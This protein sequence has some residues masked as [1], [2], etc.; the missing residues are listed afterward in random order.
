MAGFKT[1]LPCCTGIYSFIDF[2]NK[3]RVYIQRES[4]NDV[5]FSTIVVV[6]GRSDCDV[7]RREVWEV[8]AKN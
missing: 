3:Y 4:D 6:T 2:Y 1:L 8:D 5:V 7:A